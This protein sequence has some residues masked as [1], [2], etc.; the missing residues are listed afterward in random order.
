MGCGFSS[1]DVCSGKV[2]SDEP[3][4]SVDRR[5]DYDNVSDFSVE[6]R[7]Y[8]GKVFLTVV[9]GPQ[10]GIGRH[11]LIMIATPRGPAEGEGPFWLD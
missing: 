8:N 7:V 3:E 10:I 4:D 11:N 6:P 1:K 2:R 9:S 5:I